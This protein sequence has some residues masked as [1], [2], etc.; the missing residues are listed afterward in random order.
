MKNHFKSALVMIGI[1]AVTISCQE[2]EDENPIK[3]AAQVDEVVN[4]LAD[5]FLLLE[6]QGG[7]ENQAFGFRM[8]ENENQNFSAKLETE[9][10]NHPK[11][12]L[13][14]CVSSIELTESQ[15]TEIRE[16][17]IG[18]FECRLE[19]FQAF[20]EDVLEIIKSMEAHRL[21]M[22]TQLLREEIS[23]DEFKNSML[24][25]RER[26]K[27]ALEEIREKHAENL[28]PCLRGFV[29]SLRETL[30]EEDW[31]TLVNC[32]KK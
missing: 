27:S 9:K 1:L 29:V 17:F 16:I 15:K 14:N 26:Y 5:E 20:R 13:E 32:L 3:I 24:E 31:E 21:E 4:I 19:I 18:L 7:D 22:L 25:L 10:P 6:I 12:S 23:R 2:K 11:T 28:K 8:L 30:G